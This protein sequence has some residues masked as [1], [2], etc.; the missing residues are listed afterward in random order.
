[1]Q[2]IHLAMLL[3]CSLSAPARA[4][5]AWETYLEWPSPENA[6]RVERADY[7]IAAQAERLYDDL[8]LLERQI[9]A[10]DREAV[11][12]AFRLHPT[13][14]GHYAETL[15]IVLGLVIRLD[16]RTFLEELKSSVR[17]V[18]LDSLVGN[19][20]WAYVDRSD[21]QA[22]EVELRAKALRSVTDPA[23]LTVRDACLAHLERKSDR[24]PD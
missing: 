22:Y 16:P 3:A 23:L 11:R 24:L 8:G 10:L 6:T 12:L 2:R 15:D 21:A 18:A 9:L 14:D 7:S 13:S 17:Q 1:M 5:T 19:L 20:G 4:Q